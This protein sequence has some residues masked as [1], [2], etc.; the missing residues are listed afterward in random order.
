MAKIEEIK[1]GDGE[2]I[3]DIDGLIDQSGIRQ[4][5]QQTDQPQS[6][7]LEIGE[8]FAAVL[9]IIP[10]RWVCRIIAG[11]S[12]R[13]QLPIPPH[14]S[15][16]LCTVQFMANIRPRSQRNGKSSAM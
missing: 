8:A 2:N 3:E 1:E 4:K 7:D 5:L 14:G 9:Y 13:L 6:E 11:F 10:F 12:N 15:S 16:G